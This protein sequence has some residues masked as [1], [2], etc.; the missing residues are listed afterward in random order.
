MNSINKVQNPLGMR[1]RIVYGDN[2]IFQDESQFMY[3]ITY[4]VTAPVAQ[5]KTIKIDDTLE[6]YENIKT[7]IDTC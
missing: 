2:T 1:V 4:P 3:D 7:V 6:V 5:K